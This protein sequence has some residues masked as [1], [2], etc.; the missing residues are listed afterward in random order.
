MKEVE[1]R[2]V[3]YKVVAVFVCNIDSKFF[4]S[5]GR[6]RFTGVRVRGSNMSDDENKPEHR[7]SAE[8][9]KEQKDIFMVYDKV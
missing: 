2:W 9:I 5:E 1:I 8:E 3:K 6:S 7:F 4:A